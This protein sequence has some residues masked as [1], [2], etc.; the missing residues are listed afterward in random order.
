MGY[1]LAMLDR[2]LKISHVSVANDE[3]ILNVKVPSSI[4][5][6]LVFFFRTFVDGFSMKF[7]ENPKIYGSRMAYGKELFTCT[8][9][10]S[11][12]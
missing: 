8:P 12:P 7:G 2:C 9:P 11:G 3:G 1:F 10:V 4:L 5:Y 6:S